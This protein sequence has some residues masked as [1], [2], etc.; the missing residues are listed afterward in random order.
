VEEGGVTTLAFEKSNLIVN[1]GRQVLS[2][3]L[4]TNTYPC[5][6]RIRIGQGNVVGP[7]PNPAPWDLSGPTYAVWDILNPPV[8]TDVTQNVLWD[9]DYFQQI[10]APGSPVFTY[11]LPQV[12]TQ[13][14]FVVD[15]PDANGSGT[16]AY[17]EAGLFNSLGTL[18]AVENFPAIVKTSARRVIFEWLVYF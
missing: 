17:T 8:P 3:L 10:Q 18:F 7:G 1:T 11:T 13:F 14:I 6:D 5:I 9:P 4:G 2:E 16:V 12:S 15:K